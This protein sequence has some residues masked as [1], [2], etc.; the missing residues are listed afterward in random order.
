MT[1]PSNSSP[2]YSY[3]QYQV[4]ESENSNV[5]LIISRYLH[6]WPWLVLS[7]GLALA[8]AYVYLLY[9]PPIYKAQASLL[10]LDEK[11]G[12]DR[13]NVLPE[14]QSAAPKKVVENEIEIL[15]SGTLMDRVVSR[16]RL[17]N[18]Y[19]KQTK[20]GKREIYKDSP[21]ELVIERGNEALYE[22]P[23][24]LTFPDARTVRINNQAYPLNE[25]I[26]T[27]Y[28]QLKIV[29]RKPHVDLSQPV[30][31][32]ANSHGAVVGEYVSKLKAEPTSKTS[33]VVLLTLED[34]VPTKAEDVLNGVITEYNQAAILD[35]NKM[36]ANTLRF[37]QQRL[38]MVAGE[39]S[40]V[41]RQVEQYKSGRGIT[42]LSAQASTFLATAKENDSKLNEVN[43]QLAALN[44]LQKYINSQPENRGG[45]PATVGLNDP[46][47]LNLIAK[48]TELE[49]KRE[50][51][52]QTVSELSPDIQALNNQIKTV[53][54]N[55]SD[56]IATMK[57][58]LTKSQ[59]GYTAK[60]QDIESQIRTIPQQERLLTDITRQ[61]QIKNNLFTYL[62]Q[63]REETAVA[64]AAAVADSRTIDVASSSPIPV[65]PVKAMYYLLFGLAGLLFPIGVIA[66]R[67]ALNT[68]VRR[69]ADVEENT[70]VPILGE[71]V[72]SR[73]RK[74]SLVVTPKS[75]TMIAEQ[76][77]GL[78]A[79]L[80]YVRNDAHSSQVVLFTSS[81]SGEGKSFISLNLGASLALVDKPTVI[82]EMDL[83]IPRLHEVFNLD[84]S[85]GISNYLT[86]EATLD[87]V[88]KPMPGHKNYFI[89]TSGTVGENP[90]EL[91]S[92]P[93]LEQL[94]AELRTRFAYIIVD[95]PPVG[96]VSDA[97]LVA[98]LADATMFVVRHDVTPKT[99]L[100]M[101]DT[102]YR[103]GRFNR[104]NIILNAVGGTESYRSDKGYKNHYYGPERKR[105]WLIPSVSRS[106]LSNKL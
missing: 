78:R 85:V 92:S 37:I 63:K 51:K 13:S 2:G 94:I 89:I 56:N 33:S 36:A 49:A 74:S 81:I 97:Q 105:N 106:T 3:A 58:L 29:T 17:D 8:G 100:K 69:R 62:L 5:R 54:R 48:Y 41:E 59:E 22:E 77:R 86:G 75:R 98:P 50:E 60:N 52:S 47:L 4:V 26:H 44:E 20:F 95:T 104:L 19:Y 38:N 23:I 6:N 53:K 46:V 87:D 10:V 80:Q 9:K 65:K 68:R 40:G 61:Q 88:L 79:N 90:T 45:T 25:S 55:I 82:L 71:V 64:F 24:E 66:G 30:W 96:L 91:L 11:K 31:V 76:I 21:V 15:R 27:P 18:R 83:R 39:L 93:R 14:V 34:A 43:I 32:Q 84:N 28:G 103:D 1:S 67:D 16:L 7:V 57:T 73:G 72:K 102:L 101:V 35:K 42:D 12:A 99:Y 70:R